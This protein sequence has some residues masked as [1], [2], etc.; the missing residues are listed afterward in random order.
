M[1]KDDDYDADEILREYDDFEHEETESEDPIEELDFEKEDAEPLDNI[2]NE[3]GE[4][5]DLLS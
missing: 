5:N 2:E 1:I 3:P 4:S